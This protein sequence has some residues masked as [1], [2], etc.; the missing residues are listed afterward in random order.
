[1]KIEIDKSD[2]KEEPSKEDKPLVEVPTIQVPHDHELF[3]IMCKH[4]EAMYKELGSYKPPIVLDE[5]DPELW[6]VDGD[7]K[8]LRES[9]KAFLVRCNDRDEE[10]WFPRSSAI[11][12]KGVFKAKQ[13]IL[14]QKGWDVHPR[15]MQ[16]VVED[17]AK[18]RKAEERIP[19]HFYDFP[20]E[21]DHWFEDDEIPF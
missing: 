7:F 21:A 9:R 5:N 1:M 18:T 11:F 3:K 20:D 4:M 8:L 15:D 19:E 13:W 2:I 6:V 16:G 17:A 10:L 12:S 14:E